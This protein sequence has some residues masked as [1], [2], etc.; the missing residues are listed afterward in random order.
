MK[1]QLMIASVALMFTNIIHCETAAQRRAAFQASLK[2]QQAGGSASTVVNNGGSSAVSSASVPTMAQLQA[3][4]A[5]NPAGVAK[6]AMEAL[7]EL[8]LSSSAPASPIAAA[9]IAG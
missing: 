1:K 3:E 6:A 9:Y 2:K 8:G 5:S 7:Q 4:I